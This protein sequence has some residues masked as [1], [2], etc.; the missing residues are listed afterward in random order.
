MASGGG[1]DFCSTGTLSIGAGSS[2]KGNAATSGEGGTAPAGQSVGQ[3]AYA[4]GGAV[5]ITEIVVPISVTISDTTISGNAVRGAAGPNAV[6]GQANGEG[7]SA[8]GGGVYTD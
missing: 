7:A 6:A 8:D 1:V 4:V 2:I 3:Y 5:A